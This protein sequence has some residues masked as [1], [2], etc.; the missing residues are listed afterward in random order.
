MPI[1][2]ITA[3][4]AAVPR[5]FLGPFALSSLN[6]SATLAH[7]ARLV[8]TAVP[9]RH[10]LS[11][12][13]LTG[14]CAKNAVEACTAP[15]ANNSSSSS[16]DHSAGSS[17]KRSEE[18]VTGLRLSKRRCNVHLFSK[19]THELTATQS[20]H[21]MHMRKLLQRL[22]GLPQLATDAVAVEVASRAAEASRPLSRAKE[23][24]PQLLQ[25]STP[26]KNG[27]ALRSEL[28][29]VSRVIAVADPN[30]S[31][32]EETYATSRDEVFTGVNH[33]FHKRVNSAGATLRGI[34]K[35][36]AEQNALGAAAASG[37]I[38]ADVTDVFLLGAR[39]LPATFYRAPKLHNKNSAPASAT[40]SS[41][42]TGCVYSAPVAAQ[43]VAIFP[44]P[45]C[46]RHLCHVANARC[47]Q[48]RPPLRLF[49]YSTSPVVT[50]NLFA[51]A[52]ER[53]KT[54]VAPMDV[55]I[56]SG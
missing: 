16:E 31:P 22:P 45:E 6:S 40:C 18:A 30:A 9:S 5:R 8:C 35:G 10:K 54:M 49:V 27:H 13:L 55:C 15:S 34:L 12:H 51:V 19:S 41:C 3:S 11:S 7:S 52:Q 33:A 32:E 4:C 47:R 48:E 53:M 28:V 21:F 1:P 46:W 42:G 38:Y 29:V 23:G 24:A 20:T 43:A 39:I 36:C 37:C 17:P 56:V 50:L 25:A 44:C 14:A 26:S 2:R